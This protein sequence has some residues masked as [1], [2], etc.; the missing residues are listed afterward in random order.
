MKKIRTLIVDDHAL[1]RQGIS[2]ML[3]FHPDVEVVGEAGDG[4]EAARQAAKLAPD[5]ALMDIAM[6]GLGGLEA[7]LRILKSSPG[8]RIIVLSQYGDREY[9]ERFLK[10]G[11]AGYL[12]KTAGSDEL[13]AAIRA[14]AAGG[15]YLHPSIATA[16]IEGFRGDG[17]P[18][19]DYDRLTAREK[20]VLKML[21]EGASQ[22]MIAQ[23]LE[24]SPK[25]VG[26]HQASVHQKLGIHGRAELVKF[27]VK[28]GIIKLK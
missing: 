6:P 25:T 15:S 2:A 11:V 9:V 1:V 4:E 20:E 21:A 26:A 19:D 28:N 13:I 5:V 10:A 22:K 16:V 17:E 8:V 7:T 3:S 14:V 12:L 23:A 24:I 27:A 18:K